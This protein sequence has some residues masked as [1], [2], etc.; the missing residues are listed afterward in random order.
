VLHGPAIGATGTQYHV[1]A[2]LADA[3]DLLIV[4][5]AVIH[6]HDI[7]D[8]GAGAK[9]R[10][11]TLVT[12]E[13]AEAMKVSSANLGPSDTPEDEEKE[14]SVRGP[15][16]SAA[17]QLSG[18]IASSINNAKM[19]LNDKELAVDKV[20]LSGGGARVSG[21]DAAFQQKTNLAVERMNPAARFEQH[22]DAQG[23][24]QRFRAHYIHRSHLAIRPGHAADSVSV[25]RRD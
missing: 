25:A 1:G 2:K 23:V 15:V 13:D 22:G 16:R 3:L 9:G 24:R 18:F 8:N 17:G 10:A 20:Y 14:D 19:Q 4:L 21:L 7:Y 5:A 11:F 6:R 12:P